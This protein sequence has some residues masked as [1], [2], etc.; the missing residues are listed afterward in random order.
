MV[1]LFD[2]STVFKKLTPFT[3]RCHGV[4]AGAIHCSFKAT[5]EIRTQRLNTTNVGIRWSEKFVPQSRK[6]QWHGVKKVRNPINQIQYIPNVLKWIQVK[7]R[8]LSC[9]GPASSLFI[10][11]ITDSHKITQ[12]VFTYYSNK[13]IRQGRTATKEWVALHEPI[14]S[15]KNGIYVIEVQL[16]AC[17]QDCPDGYP[18]DYYQ[19][20]SISKA[21]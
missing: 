15:T 8:A 14:A 1:V 12:I 21:A 2:A 11:E 3:N 17:E 7:V 6:H 10:S 9:S 13:A 5:T 18:L 4:A 16:Y 19:E 20:E